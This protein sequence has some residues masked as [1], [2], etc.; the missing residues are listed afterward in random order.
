[1]RAGLFHATFLQKG[2]FDHSDVIIMSTHA[3]LCFN[4]MHV[5]VTPTHR[6]EKDK[7]RNHVRVY[8][9]EVKRALNE[10][11][12]ILICRTLGQY[13][14]SWFLLRIRITAS[15]VVQILKWTYK[16]NVLDELGTAMHTN[17]NC[18]Q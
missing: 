14:Q 9:D 4:F 12:N 13:S 7:T 2:G 1:M 10:C 5:I 11:G 3:N 8:Y 15:I 16:P 6:P 18:V 17:G